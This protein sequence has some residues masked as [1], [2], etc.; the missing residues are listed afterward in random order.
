MH[1]QCK[2]EYDKMKKKI[3]YKQCFSTF[4][5]HGFVEKYQSEI[6]QTGKLELSLSPGKPDFVVCK[7]QSP[8]PACTFAQS[9]P[10]LCYFLSEKYEGTT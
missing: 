2:P 8:R 9:D 6:V 7:Q 10:L 3:S 4:Q 1:A 5:L